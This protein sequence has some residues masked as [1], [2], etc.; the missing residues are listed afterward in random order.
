MLLNERVSLIRPVRLEDAQSIITHFNIVGGET[1]YHTFGLNGY[2]KTVGEQEKRIIK[3]LKNDTSL[4]LVAVM[5]KEVIGVLTISSGQ[6][7]RNH[8]RGELGISIQKKFW[9]MGIGT[10]MMDMMFEEFQKMKAL[11]KINLIV[12]E[13]NKRARH[14]YTNLGFITEGISTCYFYNDHVCSDG[15]HMG[16]ELAPEVDKTL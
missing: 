14:V 3:S 6:T 1:D 9:N 8:H 4:F 11:I 13:D 5:E 10:Q 15:I 12:H 2:Q 7:D 16:I